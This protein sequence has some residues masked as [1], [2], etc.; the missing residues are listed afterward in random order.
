MLPQDVHAGGAADLVRLDPDHPG[1]RDDAYRAR[2]NAI[3]RLALE[4]RAGD[5]PPE[6]PYSREEHGVWRAVW[7][8]LD[9]LHAALASREYRTCA[10]RVALSRDRIPQLAEVNAAI[11]GSGFAMLPVA[12]LVSARR[13]LE[14]LGQGVFLSTQYI[15][16]HSRPL[17]TPEPDVVHELVGHAATFVHPTYAALNRAF[18]QAALDADEARISRLERVYWYTLEFGVVRESG[19]ARAWGGGLLSGAGEL[20]GF[21]ERAELRPLDLAA[22]A[23]LPYDPTGLQPVLFVARDWDEV[24]GIA[25][26]LAEV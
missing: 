24:A 16:H 26:R 4:Y 14:Y 15:R 5:P 10:A 25:E 23:A 12:G 21:R 3:A 20:S 7:R 2:R 13:F 9:P 8:E 6:A 22:M 1:F 19:E 18:G 17:Y 11:A